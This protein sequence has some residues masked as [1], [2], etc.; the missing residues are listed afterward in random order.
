[1]WTARPAV[2]VAAKPI[3]YR[4]QGDKAAQIAATDFLK[5]SYCAVNQSTSQLTSLTGCFMTNSI[6]GDGCTLRGISHVIRIPTVHHREWQKGW[7]EGIKRKDGRQREK[8]EC[9]YCLLK[10]NCSNCIVGLIFIVLP[11]VFIHYDNTIVIKV[12]AKT[13]KDDD[14]TTRNMSSETIKRA[15]NKAAV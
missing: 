6:P 13:W 5:H 10:N 7:D 8:Y 15:V 3:I 14:V 4:L 1:M 12:I 9:M 2:M 11:V